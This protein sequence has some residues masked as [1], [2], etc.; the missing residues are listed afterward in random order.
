LKVKGKMNTEKK[1]K[2]YW[3]SSR[4]QI[5]N[6]SVGTPTEIYCEIESSRSGSASHRNRQLIHQDKIR[7]RHVRRLE[8]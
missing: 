7:R 4:C 3:E 5:L 6:P 1:A 8:P 2:A